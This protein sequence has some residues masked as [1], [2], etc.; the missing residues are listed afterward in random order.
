MVI[1]SFTFFSIDDDFGVL[2]KASVFSF[3]GVDALESLF[4]VESVG[5]DGTLAKPT[6]AVE[7]PGAKILF[8]SKA[9]RAATASSTVSKL[10]KLQFLCDRTLTDSIVPNVPKILWSEAGVVFPGILPSPIECVIIDSFCM[11]NNNYTRHE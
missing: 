2:V 10:I 5:V 4:L 3:P 7:K 9:S 1:L 11:F 6:R 8:C